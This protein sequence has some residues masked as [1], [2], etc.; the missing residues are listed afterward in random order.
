VLAA[1]LVATP[2]PRTDRR[3]GNQRKQREGETGNE[4]NWGD[5]KVEESHRDQNHCC[6]CLRYF[7]SQ[8]SKLLFPCFSF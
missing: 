8:V 6:Y 7:Q 2:S 3:K 4:K 1:T 5:R